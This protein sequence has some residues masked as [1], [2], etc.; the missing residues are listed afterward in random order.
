MKTNS[1]K[2]LHEGLKVV[3]HAWEGFRRE[4]G[5]ETPMIDWLFTHQVTEKHR[6]LALEMLGFRADQDYPTVSYLGNIA[7]VSAPLGVSLAA[8]DGRLDSGD[9]LALLGV[10]S[11][12][13][14]MLLA[15]EW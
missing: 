13:N 2:L 12:I 3:G 15:I 1:S 14:S 5:W 10:G 4:V 7:S 6:G 11:G 9:R 8:A